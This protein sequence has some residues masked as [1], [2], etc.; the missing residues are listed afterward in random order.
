MSIT[1]RWAVVTGGRPSQVASYLPA[2]YGV[3]AEERLLPTRVAAAL[4]ATRERNPEALAVG[5]SDSHG[6]TLDGYVLPRLASGLIFGREVE[7]ER[8]AGGRG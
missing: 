3:L 2:N 6:W 5:G 8:Q 4:S 7:V 1:T